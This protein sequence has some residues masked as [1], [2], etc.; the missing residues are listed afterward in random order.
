MAPISSLWKQLAILLLVLQAVDGNAQNHTNKQDSLL[1]VMKTA[2]ADTNK[3]NTLNALAATYYDSDADVS[4]RYGQQALALSEQLAFEAGIMR[5]KMVL[6]RCYSQQQQ[7]PQAMKYFHEARSLA[8]KLRDH[9]VSAKALVSLGLVYRQNGEMDKAMSFYKQALPIYEQG[10]FR[11]K[12]VVLLNMAI[13]YIAD[14]RY[15]EAKQYLQE[16]LAIIERNK[17]G[18]AVFITTYNNMACCYVGLEQRYDSALIYALQALELEKQTGNTRSMVTTYGCLTKI[19]MELGYA[20]YPY[21]PDSLRNKAKVLAMARRYGEQGL[22]MA[23]E[24]HNLETKMKLLYNLVQICALQ[25]DTAGYWYL[26]EYSGTVS[27]INSVSNQKAF[28]RME[29]ELKVQKTT[30]SLKYAHQKTESEK[31]TQRNYYLISVFFAGTV[32]LFFVNRQKQR[33]LRRQE[34]ERTERI[35][36][37][38]LASQQLQEFTLR[39]QEKNQI[40]EAIRMEIEKQPRQEQPNVFT[41]DAGLLT[42][43]QQSVLLTDEQWEK[44]KATFEKVHKG[45]FARLKE[46]IPELTPAETRFVMLSKLRLSNKEMAAMLGVSTDAIRSSKSRLMRKLSFADDSLLDQLIHSV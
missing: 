44:F 4:I 11:G 41:I 22:V 16:A 34:A 33:Y 17:E 43:L 46:K 9:E 8:D 12:N 40:I 13:I 28:A 42:E 31:R 23:D 10:G 25:R 35:R 14:E 26:Y 29:A 37:E 30:D 19:Y 1:A 15:K 7:L 39:I 36:V 27:K 5:S 21:T 45:Y 2:K 3:V 20:Q 6:G 24:Q 32:G 38:E 18:A